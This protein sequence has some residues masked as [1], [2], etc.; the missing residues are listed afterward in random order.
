M[1]LGEARIGTTGAQEEL[2]FRTNEPETINNIACV[3]AEKAK[4]H[5]AYA[6]CCCVCLFKHR[7]LTSKDEISYRVTQE[8]V[9]VSGRVYTEPRFL[10]VQYVRT[11]DSISRNEVLNRAGFRK[12][13]TLP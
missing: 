11:F 10:N 7:S 9:G 12:T 6:L 5:I 3:R 2:V 1:G 8:I 4:V 13:Y